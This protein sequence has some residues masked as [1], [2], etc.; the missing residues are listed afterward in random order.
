M[1]I[2]QVIRISQFGSDRTPSVHSTGLIFI[3]MPHLDLR[4]Y[5]LPFKSIFSTKLQ[6]F[7]YKLNLR[8]LYTNSMLMKCGLS[9]TEL[10][11]YCFETKESLIHLFY[12]CRFV[13]SLW[14]Q[15]QTEPQVYIQLD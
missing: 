1:I 8:I 3:L 6:P 15:F 11:S 12:E 14:L 2:R 5:Q 13:R 10:C 7:Q 9:E 4:L